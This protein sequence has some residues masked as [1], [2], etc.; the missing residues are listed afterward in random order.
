MDAENAALPATAAR[1]ERFPRVGR[2]DPDPQVTALREAILGGPRRDVPGQFGIE[3]ADGTLEGPF[4]LYLFAPAL[5]GPWQ[6]LGAALRTATTLSAR[7][8]ELGTLAAAASARSAF[9]LHAHLPLAAAAGVDD[10]TAARVLGGFTL[11]DPR[12]DALV[13]FCRAAVRDVQ[14]E[15]E[16]D[17][18]VAHFERRAVFEIVSLVGYY[19]A[20]A[21]MLALFAIEP[22][23]G[24]SR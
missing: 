20:L 14:P 18:L 1:T 17:D 13:R 12:E 7:E 24:P 23:A 9:E 11:D 22:P 4:G 2:D 15:R 16:F 21:A 6:Q 8:R 3:A 10:A 19:R 5:G